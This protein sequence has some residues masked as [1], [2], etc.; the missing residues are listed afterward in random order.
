MVTATVPAVPALSVDG[1]VKSFGGLAALQ[2]VDLRVE[3]GS[4][5]G[6][7]GPNG[8]GKSTLFD[9]ITGY[10]KCDAGTVCLA[11]RPI[12]GL[13]PHQVSRLGLIRTFQLTRVFSG[14]TVAEN[15]LVVAGRQRGRS[16]ARAWELLDL[17]GLAALADRV[18]GGL[19]Y[20]QLK[21]L[22]IAQVMMLEPQVLL[23][24][25]PMAGIDPSLAEEITDRLRSLRDDGV[26][27]LL[28]E[29]NLPAVLELCD[30][31]TVLASGRILA[32]GAPREVLQIPAVVEAFLGD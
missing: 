18:A 16:Q 9:I 12:G 5:G 25:E 29:H 14:L 2:G 23:L 26:T 1:V 27:I 11:G 8:S 3:Q 6:L 22:E 21:L 24:D 32:E 7:V 19:S 31:L 13:P 28:V 20:G 4:I 30:H 15:L 10:L 17:V